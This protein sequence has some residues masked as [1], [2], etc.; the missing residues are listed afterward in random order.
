MAGQLG[1]ESCTVLNQIVVKIDVDKSLLYVQ[2]NVPG[3]IS[4]LVRIRDAA[5]KIDK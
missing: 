1:N 2:G 5:K 4:S 3:S